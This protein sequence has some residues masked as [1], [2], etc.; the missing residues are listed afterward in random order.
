MEIFTLKNLLE[1]QQTNLTYQDQ[2]IQQCDSWTILFLKNMSYKKRNKFLMMTL[3]EKMI[4]K[5]VMICQMTVRLCS[6]DDINCFFCLFIFKP[7][8]KSQD[9]SL[10]LR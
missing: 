9:I 7:V 3:G 10:Y 2:I 5:V 4:S 8:N 1:D 6:I